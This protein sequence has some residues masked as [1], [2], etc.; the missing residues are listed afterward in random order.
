M[1]YEQLRA[2]VRGALSVTECEVL[3][4]WAAATEATAALEVGHYLGLSTC[5]LLDSLPE[6][7]SLVTIDHHNGD[8]NC[9]AT[10]PSAFSANVSRFVG[11][12]GFLDMRADMREALAALI[13]PMNHFGF[14]F[15]DADHTEQGV[16][17]FWDRARYLAAD[18]CTLI[19]DDADWG[20]QAILAELAALDGFVV[21]RDRAFWRCETA[22]KDNPDTYTLEVMRRRG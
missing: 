3:G 20:S 9:G 16:R 8:D 14:I 7:C 22:D 1:N 15:Y 18:D 19:F 17:D 21:V 12:R 2:D 11:D 13:A 10:A 5:V 4:D 6:A